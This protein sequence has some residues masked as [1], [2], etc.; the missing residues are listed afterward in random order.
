MKKTVIERA[1]VELLTLR[2]TDFE[3]QV[4]ENYDARRREWQWKV[5]SA[6][7]VVCESLK[8]VRPLCER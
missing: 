6:V 5:W 4:L 7:R 2:S 8:V 1:S 3:Q